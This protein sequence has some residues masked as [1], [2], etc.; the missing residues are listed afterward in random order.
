MSWLEHPDEL[1]RGIVVNLGDQIPDRFSHSE[2]VELTPE[3]VDDNDAL[4]QW[5]TDLHAAWAARRSVVVIW[6][7]DHQKFFPAAKTNSAKVYSIDPDFLFS[8]ERLNMLLFANNY[9]LRGGE[10]KWWLTNRALGAGCEAG[11]PADVV[12]PDGQPAWVDGGPSGAL[13]PVDYAVISGEELEF[14]RLTRIDQPVDSPDKELAQD[15]RAAT[16]HLAGAA[17]VIAPAGSGKTRTMSARLRHLLDD[18]RLAPE[19]VVAVAYNKRAADEL[20]ERAGAPTQ[21]VRTVHSLGWQI[22]RDAHANLSLLGEA[23]QR[24][25]LDELVHVQHRANTDPMAPYLEALD[26]VRLGLQ[27]PSWVEADGD[28]LEGFAAA[29]GPYR[30]QMYAA[31]SVDHAEQIY[32]AIEVLL[33]DADL[34]RKWQRRCRHLLIDEFQDLTPAYVLLL[35]LLASPRL[36]V[37]GVGDDDQVIYGYSGADPRFLTDFDQWFPGATNYALETNYRCPAPVVAAATNLLSWNR[38]RVDKAIS[39]GPGA[40][41]DDDACRVMAGVSGE[42][43][44]DA[45]D[46]IE[47]WI[48]TGTE[49]SEIAVLSRVN[50]SLI[51]VKAVLVEREIPTHD[52]LGTP[53]VQRSM[54]RALFAWLRMAQEPDEMRAADVREAIR[55]P[56]RGLNGVANNTR[57]PSR[58]SIEDLR[59]ASLQMKARHEAK[60]LEFCDDI[61]KVARAART[62]D[63]RKAV[64][65]VLDTAGLISSA[66]AFDRSGGS[67]AKPSHEDDLAAILR[68][69][70]LHPELATF[71]DWLGQAM[72]RPSSDAGVTISSVHRVKG[73]EWPKVIVFGADAGAIPHRLSDDLEEERRIFHVAITRCSDEVVIL[74]DQDRPSP[75][76]DQL[77]SVAPP[78]SAAPERPARGPVRSRLKKSASGSPSDAGVG[79]LVS[80]GGGFE[81]RI[82]SRTDD[83]VL[84][85]SESGPKMYF[86]ASEIQKILEPA[87][88]AESDEL[89]PED[90]ALFEVLRS[91]RMDRATDAGVP[92]FVVAGDATLRLIAAARPTT[93]TELL[94]IKGIGAAKLES[95]GDDIIDIVSQHTA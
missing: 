83:E 7:L 27:S 17:R 82:V 15:Q 24:R 59:D 33:R 39:P 85:G 94:A 19:S 90:E 92:A 3:L 50:A 57:L 89:S 34:R 84:I 65:A 80:I 52:Q 36:Q 49:P 41:Q 6:S 71:E 95:Y 20:R 77:T 76:L 9:D 51:P 45:A 21:T 69:A 42:M 1:G 43:A 66:K 2:I 8:G 53:S 62:G 30:E 60:W 40:R 79:D 91:W 64:A 46:R 14:G 28:D 73:M 11:G 31:R 13:A 81:G 56:G 26:Q 67:S 54:V 58:L 47:E 72:A 88:P 10:P 18:R 25:M 5:I 29:F 70:A 74:A 75:F 48:A 16:L 78:P 68:A 12:L 22:L 38:I 44:I 35:R 32:G 87:A 4:E 86:K 63:T 61:A 55:R 37:Y 93:D 23:D